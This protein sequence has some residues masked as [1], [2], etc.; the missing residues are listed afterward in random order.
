MS[1]NNGHLISR[2]LSANYADWPWSK[3]GQLISWPI[4]LLERE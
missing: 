3:Y 1:L 2:W 4:D